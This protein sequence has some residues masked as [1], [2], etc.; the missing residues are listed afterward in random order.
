LF[1]F[2]ASPKGCTLTLKSAESKFWLSGTISAKI[3]QA[4][5][6]SAISLEIELS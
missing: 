5:L 3:C 4:Q 2:E 1:L 6:Q